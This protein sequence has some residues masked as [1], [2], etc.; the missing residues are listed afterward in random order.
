MA[1]R[2]IDLLMDEKGYKYLD[3][4]AGTTNDANQ[5]G[6]VC[7]SWTRVSPSQDHHMTP[8]PPSDLLGGQRVPLGYLKPRRN[9]CLS[10]HLKASAARRKPVSLLFTFRHS[11]ISYFAI[12][13]TSNYGV[14]IPRVLQRFS[15]NFKPPDPGLVFSLCV[16]NC[17][18][19]HSVTP[20]FVLI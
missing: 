8:P 11:H 19:V 1:E 18:Y 17:A 3:K 9:C 20:T 15:I 7:F 6:S 14:D 16:C 2:A 10:S 5:K 12:A 13:K 4:V